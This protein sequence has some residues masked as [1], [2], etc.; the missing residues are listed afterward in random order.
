MNALQP[1]LAV[2]DGHVTTTSLDVARDFGRLHKNVLRAID[3]LGC[4][5]EFYERNFAP[6]Q[7]DVDLGR[8]Q[9]FPSR[10]RWRW[11]SA[12][13]LRP[14]MAKPLLR[15]NKGILPCVARLT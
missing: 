11:P 9:R 8:R 10:I 5:P 4:S 12:S 6:I 2:V 1:H 14:S 7:I 13:S 3:D 15:T